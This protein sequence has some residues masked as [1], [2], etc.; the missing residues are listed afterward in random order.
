MTKTYRTTLVKFVHS[1]Y[2]EANAQTILKNS[3]LTLDQLALNYVDELGRHGSRV[4]DLQ[5]TIYKLSDSGLAITV[6][7][8]YIY[9][10]EN[11]M[12]RVISERWRASR[13]PITK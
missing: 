2:G 13:C 6:P 10:L 12:R 4:Q 5:S 9:H 11:W 3:N 8:R 1:V 7:D